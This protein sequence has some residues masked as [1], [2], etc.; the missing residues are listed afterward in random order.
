MHNNSSIKNIKASYYLR[1]SSEFL[2]NDLRRYWFY[3]STKS[4]CFYDRFFEIFITF[5]VWIS[6]DCH[7]SLI[8]ILEIFTPW[9]ITVGF[10]KIICLN[11]L[12]EYSQLHFRYQLDQSFLTHTRLPNLRILENHIWQYSP[13]SWF[14]MKLNIKVK[15]F[16]K[17][18]FM[19]CSWKPH[20]TN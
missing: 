10:W 19:L 18:Y 5:A 20:D 4:K 3:F 11:V 7:S 9:K 1:Q 2:E 13:V 16:F 8:L 6:A 17:Y 12:I 14:K 15:A